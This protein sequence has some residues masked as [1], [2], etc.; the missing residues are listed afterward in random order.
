VSL[1][2][3]RSE[4]IDLTPTITPLTVTVSFMN[5]ITSTSGRLHSEFVRLLFL[6]DHQETDRFFAVSGVQL[7]KTDRSQFH[8]CR[9]TFT[10]H[11]KNWVDLTLTK[12][13]DLRITLSLCQTVN[14]KVQFGLSRTD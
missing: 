3:T 13:T 11:L 7:V 9:T 2:L 5:V 8:F 6:Q 10:P 14:G 12:D 4:S 1:L